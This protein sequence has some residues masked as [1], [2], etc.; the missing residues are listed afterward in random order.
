MT[1]DNNSRQPNSPTPT[2]AGVGGANEL[3]DSERGGPNR[4]ADPADA[5]VARDADGARVPQ[6]KNVRGL[7]LVRFRPLTY[8]DVQNYF[9]DGSSHSVEEEAMADIFDDFILKPDFGADADAVMKQ[10][11]KKPTGHV[12]AEYVEDMKPLMVRDILMALFDASGMD[13][14]VVM[15]GTTANVDVASGNP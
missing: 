5:R 12:T 4:F 9:G 7:G 1:D 8:G 15:D 2:T 14:D 13:A 11:G 10:L 3:P 6:D